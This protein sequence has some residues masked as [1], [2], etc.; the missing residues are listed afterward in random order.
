MNIEYL[1]EQKVGIINTNNNPVNFNG[2]IEEIVDLGYDVIV[3]F[4]DY[5]FS[6]SWK[7]GEN[8]SIRHYSCGL[9]EY[10]IP[11]KW[12][13]KHFNEYILY[14][15]YYDR[16][17]ILWFKDDVTKEKVVASI[18]NF[19]KDEHKKFKEV[20]ETKLSTQKNRVKD[21]PIKLTH[22]TACIEEGCMTEYVCHITSVE[23]AIKIIKDGK[24][25]SSAKVKGIDGQELAMEKS[26]VPGDPSDYF[27]YV[28]F[29][30]GNC[31]AGDRL[32]IER[33]LGKFPEKEDLNEKFIPGVRFYFKYKD[34]IKHSGYISDGYHYLKIKDSIDILPNLAAIATSEN[35]K[36]VL[37]GNIPS[38]MHKYFVFLDH[39]KYD[40]WT[41][42]HNIYEKV[43]RI[44]KRK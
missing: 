30:F 27:D 32:V 24:I 44:D 38:E 16:K 7:A 10:P 5:D 14:E 13:L 28:M 42:S 34:L 29:G 26:N 8:P 23:N 21:I 35:F 9:G 36:D 2:T 41:W 25:C 19:F 15:L 3:T 20:I 11:S 39:S 6:L 37:M 22:C 1:I 33:R 18:L 12:E 43:K 40:I 17:V 4:A 31:Q